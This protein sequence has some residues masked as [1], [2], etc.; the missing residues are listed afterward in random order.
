MIITSSL[1]QVLEQAKE[2]GGGGGNLGGWS[3]ESIEGKSNI[4]FEGLGSQEFRSSVIIILG[5][6]T[7][8]LYIKLSSFTSKC[9]KRHAHVPCS[10]PCASLYQG[11]LLT[12]NSS[13]LDFN[14]S[15]LN[16]LKL[17]TCSHNFGILNF[18]IQPPQAKNPM[19]GSEMFLWPFSI[20]HCLQLLSY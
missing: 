15:R 6:F 1:S 7:V 18:T 16:C 20:L 17:A 5:C 2:E 4:P 11:I 12:F 10:L 19:V 14:Y 8:Q 9:R 3:G 13:S